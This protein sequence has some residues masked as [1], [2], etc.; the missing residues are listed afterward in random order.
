MG[1]LAMVFG[2]LF[3]IGLVGAV[4]RIISHK[5]GAFKWLASSG[6]GL[7]LYV[8]LLFLAGGH[9]GPREKTIPAQAVV[10]ATAKAPENRAAKGPALP[11]VPSASSRNTIPRSVYSP[12]SRT[13]PAS[14]V[15]TVY[16]G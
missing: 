9:Y 13:F 16:G 6:L 14:T 4:Y 7:V 5:D 15:K 11:S 2:L 1:S 3:F 12:S 8:S 10:K